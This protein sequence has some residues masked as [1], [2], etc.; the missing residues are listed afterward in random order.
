[1][2]SFGIC[3]DVVYSIGRLLA[4]ILHDRTTVNIIYLGHFILKLRFGCRKSLLFFVF[5][6]SQ[7]DA[8]EFF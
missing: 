4:L 8:H 5:C 7:I 3:K 6:R 2:L 1:M